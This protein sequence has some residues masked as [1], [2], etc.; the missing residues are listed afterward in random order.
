MNRLAPRSLA[1]GLLL[2]SPL[3]AQNAWV[4]DA[5]GGPG[6]DFTTIQPAVDAASDGDL[7]LVREGTYY[8]DFFGGTGSFAVDAKSITLQGEGSVHLG[9]FAVSNLALDQYFGMRGFQ[10]DLDYY[11]AARLTD[12]EGPVVLEDVRGLVWLWCENSA[13]VVL[14]DAELRGLD[15]APGVLARN[16]NLALFG[17][18]VRGANARI[19][20][21]HPEPGFAGLDLWNSTAVAVG[22]SF[23]GGRGSPPSFV[24]AGPGGPGCSLRDGSR[25]E[26]Q[27]TVS[28]GGPDGNNPP[29]RFGPP[30]DIESGSS[31]RERRGT[32]R[33]LQV[34]SPL[35]EG[36]PA[37]LVFK[38]D[39]GDVVH[40]LVSRRPGALT[41]LPRRIGPRAIGPV[42]Q[43]IPIG[44]IPAS[45]VLHVDLTA[46]PIPGEWHGLVLQGAYLH[47]DAGVL[48]LAPA[49]DQTGF[50][51]GA[52]SLVNLLDAGF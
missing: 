21:G 14:K 33:T 43:T 46:P 37:P 25:L 17:T 9:H 19:P 4:V 31:L 45:G 12:N 34:P 50:V 1:L 32:V 26:V 7:I 39:P 36:E 6:H 8:G 5:A 48:G 16:S 13:S 23:E 18:H 47:G 28:I 24:E 2:A 3:P 40:L 42:A 11:G 44:T 30:Y 15:R 51:Y 52:P 22:C 38:G 41:T 20:F 27:D 35:R 49:G 10:L 29:V